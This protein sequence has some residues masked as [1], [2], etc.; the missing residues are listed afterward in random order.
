LGIQQVAMLTEKL[1]IDLHIE[2][3][4]VRIE[5]VLHNAGP[6]VTVEAGF[7][8]AVPEWSRGALLELTLDAETLRLSRARLIP[9]E[10]ADDGAAA[11]AR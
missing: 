4:E 2:H 9:V 3:A 5:Y 8:S 6:K 1:D 7:P 10:I 11:L